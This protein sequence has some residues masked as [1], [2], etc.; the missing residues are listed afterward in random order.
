[1]AQRLSRP[2][3]SPPGSPARL[4]RRGLAPRAHP[5]APLWRACLVPWSQP[6][7]VPPSPRTAGRGLAEGRARAAAAAAF[8]L[9]AG[10]SRSP[11]PHG[12]LGASRDARRGGGPPWRLPGVV[13]ACPPPPG[14]SEPSAHAGRPPAAASR[15][16]P[17]TVLSR[18]RRASALAPPF[19][20]PCLCPPGS[21]TPAQASGPGSA[22]RLPRPCSRPPPLRA[23][24]LPVSRFPLQP[25]SPSVARG[26]WVRGCGEGR[27]CGL[28]ASFGGA[29]EGRG[30]RSAPRGSGVGRVGGGKG[31]GEGGV[32]CSAS[33]AAG[34]A[35]R[36]VGA[37]SVTGRQRRGFRA[38]RGWPRMG[39]ASRRGGLWRR[40]PPPA[41]PVSPTPLSRYLARPGA[42][43]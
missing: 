35:R 18:S 28:K 10:P 24:C 30:V 29:W 15:R 1:M 40:V 38:P 16:P 4:P 22:P 39:S 8:V 25:P 21:P 12:A 26:A 9:G 32:G 42:E 23:P 17:W 19:P 3:V 27:G 5:A 11:C 34:G 2:P 14:A 31:W 43:V 13:R 36:G 7:R 41:S 37:S 6:S 33:G 20:A